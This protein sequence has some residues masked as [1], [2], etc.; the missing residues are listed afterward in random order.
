MTLD[1]MTREV[2][3]VAY[4]CAVAGLDCKF[5]PTESEAFVKVRITD[6]GRE[7]SHVLTYRLG[8]LV[9]AKIQA[10]SDAENMEHEPLTE[11]DL[12]PSPNNVVILVE[13]SEDLPR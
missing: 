7:I 10:D 5:S 13:S 1:I 6:R 3:A 11:N 4:A 2:D 9:Q 8:A 12:L